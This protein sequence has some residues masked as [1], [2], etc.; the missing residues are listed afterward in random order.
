MPFIRLSGLGYP[1]KTPYSPE[2]FHAKPLDGQAEIN[3]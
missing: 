3:A 1:W 2:Y